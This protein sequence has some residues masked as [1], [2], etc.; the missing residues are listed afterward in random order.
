M[1]GRPIPGKNNHT[2][3]GN[4]AYTPLP[5]SH[6]NRYGAA[7]GGPVLPKLWGGKTYVFAIYE[8]YR[9]PNATHLN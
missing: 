6:Y 2:R 3:S 8:G 1:W 7:V 5:S 4:L 9:F